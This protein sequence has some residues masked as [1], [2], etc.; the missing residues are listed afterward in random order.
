MHEKKKKVLI[1]AG[2]TGGHILPAICIADHLKAIDPS[3]EIKFVHG[4]SDFEKKLYSRYSEHCHLLSVGR[5]RKNVSWRERG[6]TFFTLPFT[7]LKALQIIRKV[8]PEL[9]LGTGGSVSG[10]VLLAATLYR[11]RTL[12]WEPNTIPGLTNRWLA[13]FVNQIIIIFEETKKY[14]PTKKQIQLPFP[15]RPEIESVSLKEKPAHPLQILI[16]GGSQGSSFI[17]QVVSKTIVNYKTLQFVHQCGQKDFENLK[18]FYKHSTHIRLFSFIHDVHT[19]YKWADLVI[20]RSGVGTLAEL[21]QAGRACVLVPLSHSADQHQ[22]KNALALLEQSAALL[23]EESNFS[24]NSLSHILEDLNARPGKISELS[25]NIHKMKLGSGAHKT[26]SYL[27][28]L[29]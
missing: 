6:K 8:K 10:P 21:S 26:A 13:P 28:S 15:V 22:L 11:K 20:C 2:G 14:F 19:F 3:I 18:K 23:I 9:V 24:V 5:L 7:F 4:P 1:A 25:V 12:I 29:L 27:L 16:L 17:N